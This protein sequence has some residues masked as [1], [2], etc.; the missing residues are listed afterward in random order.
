VCRAQREARRT[1]GPSARTGPHIA[2]EVA[3]S[4]EH[5]EGI[6]ASVLCIGVLEFWRAHSLLAVLL[7][8]TAAP[9]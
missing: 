5:A 8:R 6:V 7:M 2:G 4:E 3:R 9:G 1:I